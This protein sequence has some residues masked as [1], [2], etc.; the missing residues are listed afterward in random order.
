MGDEAI[1]ELCE[2]LVDD[3][4]NQTLRELYLWDNHLTDVSVLA[5]CDLLRR[6][7][8]LTKCELDN[9]DEEESNV[10]HRKDALEELS[11]MLKRNNTR[12]KSQVKA[13]NASLFRRQH[14]TDYE[15]V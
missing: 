1:I 13:R 15:K 7:T 5:L 14:G 2:I 9:G 11:R 6:N 4:N 3:R 10:I 12:A 8:T